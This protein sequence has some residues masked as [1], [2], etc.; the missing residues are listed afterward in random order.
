MPH[1]MPAVFIAIIKTFHVER[2]I[3]ARAGFAIGI[4]K[5]TVHVIMYYS[6]GIIHAGHILQILHFI[7][8]YKIGPVNAGLCL[9]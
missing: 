9:F 6:A 8:P 5:N 2:P 3:L 7:S 1:I 4:V